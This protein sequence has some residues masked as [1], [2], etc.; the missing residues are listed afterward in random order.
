MAV[1]ETY[2]NSGSTT[3][4]GTIT[5]G[6]ASLVVN[7]A[8]T[9]P[10]A[11]QF[12]ILVDSEYMLVTSLVGTT[13]N[14]TRGIEGSVAASHSDGA[15]I[16]QVLTSGGLVGVAGSVNLSDKVSNLPSTGVIG[17]L[18]VPTDASY[19][20]QEQ[21][22]GWSAYG[23][24]IPNL[25]SPF[26][27]LSNWTPISFDAGSTSGQIGGVLRVFADPNA[28]S[29]GRIIAMSAPT[30]GYTITALILPEL[31]QAQFASCGIGWRD[32]ATDK[33]A[34]IHYTGNTA[35]YDLQASYAL[36]STSYFAAHYVSSL[37][38]MVNM[39]KPT[40]FRIQDDGINRT[41]S[42]SFN[43]YTFTQLDQRARNY[44]DGATTMN[45]N[46]VIIFVASIHATFAAAI[47]VYS[48]IT[49]H[50]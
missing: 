14:I 33:Q 29:N 46:Q 22:S 6:A 44:Y 35:G 23:P 2:S 48:W 50:P 47:T 34:L 32:S 30:T 39:V 43:G 38:A 45:P 36:N 13:F 15:V 10:L 9:F 5:A 11:P 12:R 19:V 40:W 28:G 26:P 21:S 27:A 42:Y 41:V 3:L 18:F 17:R 37:S 49:T 1:T 4:S 31:A 25:S 7:S 24:V 20:Y 8:A 16:T